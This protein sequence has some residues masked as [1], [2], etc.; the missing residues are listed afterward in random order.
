MKK[1]KITKTE[2][3]SEIKTCDNSRGW[4]ERYMKL[5]N[6]DELKISTM[7]SEATRFPLIKGN[8]N[9]RFWKRFL[10]SLDNHFIGLKKTLEIELKQLE[11]KK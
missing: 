9:T 7:L 3:R 10:K 2:I 8:E 11:E 4:I 6:L 5:K 1:V